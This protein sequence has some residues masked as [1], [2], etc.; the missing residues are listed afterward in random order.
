MTQDAP[1]HTGRSPRLP[2]LAGGSSRVCLIRK[3]PAR[4]R[5]QSRGATRRLSAVPSAWGSTRRLPR[6]ARKG[7][8][9]GSGPGRRHEGDPCVAGQ[10]L[11]GCRIK[12]MGRAGD[13]GSETAHLSGGSDL[14]EKN[15][16][17]RVLECPALPPGRTVYCLTEVRAGGQG[18]CTAAARRVWFRFQ[19]FWLDC[20]C[21]EP[22]ALAR[23][24]CGQD[25][26]K[27]TWTGGVSVLIAYAAS[28]AETPQFKRPRPPSEPTSA[29]TGP[30]VLVQRRLLGRGYGPGGAHSAN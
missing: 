22:D 27:A 5:G 7:Q 14:T 4:L 12:G 16:M 1:D 2:R 28:H 26:D 21:G 29:S 8:A 20:R 9:P 15:T 23:P 30:Q 3:S 18:D 6:E 10:A 11:G 19:Y 17:R 25:V 24:R 13:L